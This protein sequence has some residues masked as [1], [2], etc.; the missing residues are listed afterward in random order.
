MNVKDELYILLEGSKRR[1]DIKNPSGISLKFQS[2]MFNDLSKF[3]AS[4]S[5]TFKIP[6]TRNNVEAFDLVDELRHP[7][8]AYGKK[9]V[10]EFYRDGIKL[11]N[12]SYLYINEG[13][14]EY[15]AV[16]TWNVLSWLQEIN[17][18]GKSL[19]DIEKDLAGSQMTT[20]DFGT[21]NPLISHQQDMSESSIDAYYRCGTLGLYKRPKVVPVR[22]LLDKISRYYGKGDASNIFSFVRDN[23]LT[24]EDFSAADTSFNIVDDGAIPMVGGKWSNAYLQTQIRQA[25][26]SEVV[27][28]TYNDY[29]MV[30]RDATPLDVPSKWDYILTMPG[31]RQL[32]Y[33]SDVSGS[34]DYVKLFKH[35]GTAT[36]SGSAWSKDST[37]NGMYVGFAPVNNKVKLVLRGRFRITGYGKLT[38]IPFVWNLS[39]SGEI[40]PVVDDNGSIKDTIDIHATKVEGSDNLYEIN[41]DPE[42]GGKEVEL[43][44]V[45]NLLMWAIRIDAY[46]SFIADSYIKF[47][48]NR[49]NVSY[50]T[51]NPKS[52]DVV[53][54]FTNLPDI[55][56]IDF[57]KSLFYIENSYPIIERDGRIGQM[58]YEDLYRNIQEGKVYDWSKLLVGEQKNDT[59]KY[60]TGN[61]GMVN[62]FNMKN[63]SATSKDD[64]ESALKYDE[65]SA[66]FQTD[67]EYLPKESTIFT[68]PYASAARTTK[69][70]SSAGG[71]FIFWDYDSEKGIYKAA[72]SIDPIIGR[73]RSFSKAFLY[74]DAGAYLHVT[75]YLKFETWQVAS[76]EYDNTILANIFKKPYIIETKAILDTFALSSLDFTKPV[77]L[78]RYNA[79][80]A[81]I[82][83]T[84]DT[85]GMSK[86]ELIRLPDIDVMNVGSNDPEIEIVGSPVVYK[87]SGSNAPAMFA[88]NA[89]VK[90]SRINR[91]IVKLDGTVVADA[92]MEEFDLHKYFDTGTHVVEVEVFA[93]NGRSAT[94]RYETTVKFASNRTAIDFLSFSGGLQI[95]RK[96][97]NTSVIKVAVYNNTTP[98]EL[99]LYKHKRGYSDKVLLGSTTDSTLAVEWE[100]FEQ[101]KDGVSAVDWVITAEFDDGTQ[102]TTTTREVHVSVD[103][104]LTKYYSGVLSGIY[105]EILTE[106]STPYRELMYIDHAFDNGDLDL[107]CSVL[108]GQIE[109][110]YTEIHFKCWDDDGADFEYIHRIDPWRGASDLV[111]LAKSEF[112]KYR[113]I[114]VTAEARYMAD[115][116]FY[117]SNPIWIYRD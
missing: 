57:M 60:T 78:T 102:I 55:K 15:S 42:F 85:N 47:I 46:D 87:S 74:L 13:G 86:V 75:K 37:P 80:F 12:D 109:P 77:Y 50:D 45:E 39:S 61:L 34:Q 17:E 48:P 31:D 4:Y 94:S 6:K 11:F 81:I 92:D 117:T 101:L 51:V 8:S 28:N 5:Y 65:A 9:M 83:V 82:S 100:F 63:Y 91:M 16:M 98:G 111:T 54:L 71:T 108:G 70:G 36:K 49:D 114:K 56:I 96:T 40:S 90:E 21:D 107:E 68:F 113:T 84:C 19:K 97:Q 115:D 14:N 7:S 73:I 59:V 35:T 110:Y 2:N 52:L 23:A 106:D 95:S 32:V 103:P 10:C 89:S 62:R 43:S 69:Q 64:D 20:A 112:G 66:Y 72:G 99:R 18:S 116:V 3:C 44:D 41:F 27:K 22:Y 105:F 33:F 67:S 1:I 29:P 104:E 58:R 24:N 76:K 79:F 93:A 88:I 38:L 25:L 26:R 53:D 30:D